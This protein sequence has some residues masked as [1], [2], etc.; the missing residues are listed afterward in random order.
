LLIVGG[1]AVAMLIAAEY[2]M[3][4][5]RPAA[6]V[7]K[8][9]VST[10]AAEP[11]LVEF[12]K[13]RGKWLRPDGGYVLEFKRLLPQNDLEA[14]YFNPNPIHVAKARLYKERGFVKVFVELRDV[15]YPGSTY[16]L[17]YDVANDQLRGAYF[18][19]MQ[20]Q[21]YEVAFERMPPGS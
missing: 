4:S 19:A 21:E 12:D 18:Q 8:P 13:L 3:F 14:A 9:A 5:A 10:A 15:N 2:W 1:V 7:S 6:V 16:T 17:I 20:Q 11:V